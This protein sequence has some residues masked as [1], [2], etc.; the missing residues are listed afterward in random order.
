MSTT[1]QSKHRTATIATMITAAGVIIGSIM[2]WATVTGIIQVDIAGTEGDGKITLALG[3]AAALIALSQMN[4]QGGWA[5]PATWGAMLSGAGIIVA[6][7]LAVSNLSDV[8]D[9][10]P[11]AQVAPGAG[12]WIVLVSGV[13]VTVATYQAVNA[14]AQ[15]HPDADD[16]VPS[17]D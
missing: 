14:P 15:P 8:A 7:A 13:A 4:K 17:E 2:P 12:L 9:A 16:P 10:G 6:A 1:D 11:F 5:R 3:V